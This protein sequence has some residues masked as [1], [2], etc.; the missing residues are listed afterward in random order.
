MWR[1]RWSNA[2]TEACK[3]IPVA[4]AELMTNT[5]IGPFCESSP[6][7]KEEMMDTRSG[8]SKD[9]YLGTSPL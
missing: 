9:M 5:S 7:W 4:P 8:L 1:G 3:D 2:S 6:F